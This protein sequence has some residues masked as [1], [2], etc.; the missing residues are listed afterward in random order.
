MLKMP[1]GRRPPNIAPKA[2]YVK[3]RTRKLSG[4]LNTSELRLNAIN[5]A[6]NPTIPMAISAINCRA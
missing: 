2:E 4:P 1:N 3:R 5:I 6:E